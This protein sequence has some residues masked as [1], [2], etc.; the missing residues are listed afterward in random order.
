MIMRRTVPVGFA[1]RQNSASCIFSELTG[2]I[3][4]A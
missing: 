3:L 4:A 2:I 1:D